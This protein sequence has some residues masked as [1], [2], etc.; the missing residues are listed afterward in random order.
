MMNKKVK[1]SNYCLVGL[2]VLAVGF[3]GCSGEK[4]AYVNT[5]KLYNEFDY[6]KELENKIVEVR[7]IR[8]FMLD[9]MKV[10]LQNIANILDNKTEEDNRTELIGRFEILR[11][12]YRTKQDEFEES[13]EILA[14]DYTQKIWD[15]LNQYVNDFGEKGGYQYIYG[16]DGE[17]KMMYADKKFDVTTE[18]TT[19]VNARYGGVEK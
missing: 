15:Q 12:Q 9:S 13:N 10:E 14:E 19:Y 3:S 2:L 1:L 4:T 8:K 16:A 7:K 18:L 6:K 5:V 17:G 11:A